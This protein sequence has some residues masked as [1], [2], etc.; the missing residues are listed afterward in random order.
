LS[1]ST[2]SFDKKESELV[3]IVVQPMQPAQTGFILT[4]TLAVLLTIARQTVTLMTS[5]RVHTA[6]VRSA[7]VLIDGA[8]V[9]IFTPEA[10]LT[11]EAGQTVALVTADRVHTTS[12][13]VTEV[14]DRTSFDETFV[15][16]RTFGAVAD[17]P[18][19]ARALELGAQIVTGGV[20][21]TIVTLSAKVT[22][23]T[24]VA[25]AV[26]DRKLFGQRTVQFRAVWLHSSAFDA[27]VL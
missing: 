24:V 1:Q 22:S 23:R 4:D 15:D 8:L 21:M 11:I 13:L 14:T 18:G 19:L 17:E 7:L 27:S 16:V 5:D 6:T 2:E 20:L 9:D 25:A 10:V 26:I 12:V 3:S